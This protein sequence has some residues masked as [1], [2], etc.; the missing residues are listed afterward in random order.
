[1]FRCRVP[2]C[3]L[4]N[5]TVYLDSW[6]K[7]AIPHKNNRIQKCLRYATNVTAAARLATSGEGGRCP[8][9]I[10][11]RSKVE[12]CDDFVFK[13][14]EHRIIREVGIFNFRTGGTPNVFSLVFILIRW[15]LH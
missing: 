12:R 4:A 2:E 9:D 13:T 5:E 11:D 8:A 7:E 3:D 6:L 1:M 14:N 15:N 10:F